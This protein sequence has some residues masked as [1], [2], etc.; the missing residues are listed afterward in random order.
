MKESAE[1]AP[2][3]RRVNLE[4][5]VQGGGTVC[6]SCGTVD[7]PPI[8]K[9]RLRQGLSLNMPTNDGR[10]RCGISLGR[11]PINLKLLTHRSTVEP[12]HLSRNVR[13]RR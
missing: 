10:R 2:P 1:Q 4:W 13:C 6:S 5:N 7:A 3:V 11:N 8:V 12:N 9:C